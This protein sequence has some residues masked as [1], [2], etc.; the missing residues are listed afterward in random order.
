M[1]MDV[2]SV[3]ILHARVDEQGNFTER[4]YSGLDYCLNRRANVDQ[5]GTAFRQDLA[6]QLLTEGYIA[7]VPVDMV[8]DPQIGTAK[9]VRTIRVG[10]IVEWYPQEVRVDVY[11]EKRG[12]REQI[13]INKK[14]VAIIYNPLYSIMNQQNSTFQR[15]I[16]KLALLDNVDEATSSG[17]IDVIIQ[18]PY[19]VKSEARLAQAR[20]RTEELEMQLSSSK[21][22]V[23]WSDGTEKITQL[24]RAVENSLLDH[25]KY[26]MD[27]FY[28]QLGI[29][30]AVLNGTADELTISNYRN[31]TIIPIVT[32]IL[33]SLDSTFITNTARTQGHSL[34]ALPNVLRV[35]TLGEF[36]AAV[37][38]L[39]RNEV[40]TTNEIRPILGLPPSK[41][42][43]ADKLR[44]ANMPIED[45]PEGTQD[46]DPF[47]E[48]EN[49]IDSILNSLG[50]S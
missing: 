35:S 38:I 20:R 7:V 30:E 12:I 2:A 22:G 8:I 10:R 41:E 49:E 19:V 29:S 24:N 17:K 25:I 50:V 15:V 27:L 13:L 5:M 14:Q 40:I 11:N 34:V 26:L 4:I 43:S 16:R 44:N 3:S 32:A 45:Q 21:Y 33:E 48:I 46:P 42:P 39:S 31:R 37:D 47:D 36:A 18:L 23:A 1:A 9:D 28:S 6:E